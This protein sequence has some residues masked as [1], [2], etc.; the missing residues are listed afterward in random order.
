MFCIVAMSTRSIEDAAIH[1]GNINGEIFSDFISWSFVPLL[2]PFDGKNSKS[3]V[4]MDNASINHV[5]E[6]ATNTQN[7]GAILHYLPPYSPDYNPL[8]ESFSKVNWK[9]NE[10]T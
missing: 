5:E 1:E 6:V 4:V 3:V 10:V 8:E 7:T 2:Q 9:L